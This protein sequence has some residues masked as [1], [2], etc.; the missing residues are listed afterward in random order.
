MN[1]MKLQGACQMCKAHKQSISIEQTL[2]YM[3]REFTFLLRINNLTKKDLLSCESKS[4]YDIPHSSSF[5]CNLHRMCGSCTDVRYRSFKTKE[6]DI[7]N[8]I[9][10]LLKYMQINNYI[11]EK[12]SNL[13]NSCRGNYA[14]LYR[15]IER[16]EHSIKNELNNKK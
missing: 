1:I 2:D 3:S 14:S 4:S 5:E 7:L 11:P 13:K 16:L 15:H 6:K 12:L 10:L 8:N 9:C